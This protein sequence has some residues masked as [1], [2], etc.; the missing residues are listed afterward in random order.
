M[1]FPQPAAAPHFFLSNNLKRT[2]HSMLPPLAD[3]GGSRMGGTPELSVG[4]ASVE[5]NPLSCICGVPVWIVIRVSATPCQ[6]PLPSIP[7]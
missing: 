2:R 1:T 5:R 6:A 4:R 3:G 7:V